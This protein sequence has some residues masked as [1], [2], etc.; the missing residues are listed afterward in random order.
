[1]SGDLV[2]TLSGANLSL[3]EDAQA[4]AKRLGHSGADLVSLAVAMSRRDQF[5][6]SLDEAYGDGFCGRLASLEPGSLAIGDEDK[7]VELLLD[8]ES[9]SG[10]T[11][12]ELLAA[13]AP[14]L[15]ELLGTSGDHSSNVSESGDPPEAKPVREKE[16][17][18]DDEFRGGAL[19]P[20]REQ[21]DFET[22]S[23]SLKG[24]I[25]GQD[26]AIATVVRRLAVT[27][28]EL[29]L[30]PE[31]PDGVF[32]FVGPTGVGKTELA[33]ALAAEL[34]GD[35]DALIRLDMSEY[36]HDWAISR[37]T[38]PMPGYSGSDKPDSWLTTRVIR[39]PQSVLLLDEVEKAHPAVWNVFLQAFD[40]GRLTD[41][42]GKTA[43][44]SGIIVVMTSNLGSGA[45]TKSPL[46]FA[47]GDEDED[48]RSN[49]EASSLV[50]GVR[51]ALPPELM[52]RIDCVVPF[53]ALTEEDIRSIAKLELEQLTRRLGDRNISLSIS[54]DVVELLSNSNYDR[55]YGA[56]HL[57]RNLEKLF[58]EPLALSGLREGEVYARVEDGAVHFTPTACAR[59]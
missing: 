29:D 30:R 44:F 39:S 1:M 10:D 58:L 43:D 4:Q 13:R 33:H 25:R 45:F 47:G 50:D 24:R 11:L 27:S 54:D 35:R 17:D 38:G 59:E 26:Q 14:D 2:G 55:N 32:M 21:V 57:H 48:E 37:L 19:K 23:T 12:T 8:S 15:S 18:T 36:A 20:E 31:R 42:S 51:K 41:S 52:N 28:A 56:R 40:A 5:S 46:G 6:G 7:V 22:L 53:D 16:P 9:G 3:L 49:R 34:M